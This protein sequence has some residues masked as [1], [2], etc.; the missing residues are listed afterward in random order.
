MSDCFKKNDLVI[1]GTRQ[2]ERLPK[3][4]DP[5]YILPDERKMA[6]LMVFITKYAELLKYYSA[7][8]PDQSVYKIDG[9]WKPF[10]LSDEAFNYAGIAVTRFVLPNI[11]FYRYIGLYETESSAQW[12]LL[13]KGSAA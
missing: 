4:L 9:D 3:P 8:E 6:D 1:P 5:H 13:V 10:I 7:T 2:D 11:T 12:I